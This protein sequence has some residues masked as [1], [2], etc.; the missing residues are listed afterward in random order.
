MREFRTDGSRTGLGSRRTWFDPAETA[1]L[2]WLLDGRLTDPALEPA[3]IGP[4]G[5]CPRHAWGL[6]ALEAEAKDG[7]VYCTAA[8][9]ARLLHRAAHVTAA[10]GLLGSGAMRRHLAQIRACVVCER[11]QADADGGEDSRTDLPHF[12]GLLETAS[13]RLGEIACPHCLGGAGMPCRPHLR[14]GAAPRHG[15]SR[16]LGRLADHLTGVCDDL[17]TDVHPLNEDEA[18]AW[19]ESVGWLSGWRFAGLLPD[20]DGQK[21][22]GALIA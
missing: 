8:L 11:V 20:V 9:H 10:W 7:V 17:L 19:V 2:H 6:A 16:R 3:L 14:A 18:A 12:R 15:L 5:L 4:L 13:P 21:P 22:H 1:A